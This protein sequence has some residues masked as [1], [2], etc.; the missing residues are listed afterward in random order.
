M[1]EDKGNK[2]QK[3]HYLDRNRILMKNLSR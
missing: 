1:I 2:I 3:L